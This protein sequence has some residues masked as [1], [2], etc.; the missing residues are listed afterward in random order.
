[1]P[2][3]EGK[4]AVVTGASSGIGEAT[5][6]AL[7]AEGATVVV[8]ARREDR[9]ADLTKRIEDN[10]GRVL[11]AACDVTDEAQAHGL[12]RRAEEEFG[13]VDILVNNAGVMLLSQVGKGLSDEWRRMFDTNV[14]GLLY[15]TDAAIETMKRQGGGHLVNVSSVAG[16]KVTRDS[17]GV[18]AGSKHAV[19]A[20]SEGLRQELLEDNIRVTIVEPGA[21]ATELTDHITDE[22]AREG[23]SGLLNL[24]IL[25]AEDIAN[26]IVYAVTQP[27]RVSVNEILIRPTQ[28]P[29]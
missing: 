4:V 2:K 3:L 26:A 25:Q 7:A 12:I 10:G 18:Y 14:L 22:D 28:Q 24:E 11:A 20:I 16:R 13:R 15:A 29:V 1:M 21:V 5:A 6:E 9:L 17:S 8:A 23:L 19:G 27:E